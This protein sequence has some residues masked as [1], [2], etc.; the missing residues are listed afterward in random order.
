MIKVELELKDIDYDSL[1]DQFLPVMIEKLRQSDNAASR[2]IS[3]GMPASM[4]KMI[5]KK[6][7]L[8]TKEQLTSELINSNKDTIIQFIQDTARHN[9]FRM[10][11]G[12][13]RTKAVG[14]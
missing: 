11:I 2:L 10:N 3:S 1:I 7:P 12:D 5:L 6:L 8:A 9:N 14:N 4:A 13:F